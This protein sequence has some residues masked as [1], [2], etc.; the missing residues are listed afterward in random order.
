MEDFNN[1]VELDKYRYTN[2][3]IKVVQVNIGK[4]C[5]LSCHHCHVEAGP[6][7]TEV[8]SK[9]VMEAV[10][11]YVK[12]FNIDTVDIT[13]G[14]PSMHPDIEWF[15]SSLRPFANNIIVRTNAVILGYPKFSPLIDVYKKNKVNLVCSLPCY[16]KENVDAQRGDGTYDLEIPVIKRLNEV[17]YGKNPD[18]ELDLVYNPGGAFLPGDQKELEN[19]YKRI[20]LEDHGI[21]FNNLYT[22]TNIPMGRFK[23]ELEEKDILEEYMDLLSSS[24]NESAVPNMM[25]RNQISVAYDGKI[26][27]CDFNQALNMEAEGGLTIFNLINGDME[28]RKIAFDNHCYACVAGAGSSCGGAL[29]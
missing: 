17:G 28:K 2:D 15:I 4:R 16:T 25:C 6:N 14:E 12:K 19:D 26:Y 7:R 5:N 9:D 10:I 13:G 29:V 11:S 8:M 22:I 18:L 20:L 1:R 24:F 3:H 27:D 21:V 23:E